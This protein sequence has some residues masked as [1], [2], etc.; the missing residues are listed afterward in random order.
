MSRLLTAS[1]VFSVLFTES[2]GANALN[3]LNPMADYNTNLSVVK[4]SEFVHT[5]ERRFIVTKRKREFCFAV[6]VT[7]RLSHATK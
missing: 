4:Y 7:V 5:Q 2:G 3:G 1:Q 6:Y